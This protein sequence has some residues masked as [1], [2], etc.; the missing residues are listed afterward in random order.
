MKIAC[1]NEWL[2]R[3]A[4]GMTLVLTLVPCSLSGAFVYEAS[5]EFLSS[6]DFNADGIADV[7][8]LDKNTGNARVGYQNN[9]GALTWSAPLVTGIE[10]P[11]GC[12]LGRL[13]QSDRDALAVTSPEHNR[14]HLVNLSNTNAAGAPV[15]VTPA[16]IGPNLLI[17]LAT[18]FGTNATFDRLLIASSFNDVHAQG[19]TM[20]ELFA[21]AGTVASQFQGRIV[22][23]VASGNSLRLGAHPATF[24]AA[25]A[26]GSNAQFV[27]YAFTNQLRLV[28]QLSNLPPDTEYVFGNFNGEALPRFLFYVPGESNLL[29][30][31][32]VVAGAAFEFGSSVPVAL[33]QA[34]ERVYYVAQ[35]NDGYAI[36]HFRDGIQGLRVSGGTPVLASLYQSGLGAAGNVFTGVV[37]LGNGRFALLD[38]PAGAISTT[39]AQVVEF[40]GSSYTQRTNSNLSPLSTRTTRANLWLFQQEPF[41]TSGATFIGSLNAPDW[42]SVPSG[43]PASLSARV[44]TDGGSSSG[45]GSPSVNSLGTPPPG[46]AFGLPNQYRDDISFFSYAP[47][48]LEPLA[49]TISPPPG[50]YNG[51]IN[52]SFAASASADIFYR[53]GPA[54]GWHFYIVPFQLTNDATMQYYGVNRSTAAR[55]RLQSATYVLGRDN[56]PAQPPVTDPGN[57]NVPP[58]VDT[59]RLAYSSY[60]TVFY[61]RRSFFFDPNGSI[62][63]INLDGSGDRYVTAGARPR[64]SS[65]GRYLAFARETDPFNNRGNLWIRDLVTGQEAR[66]FSNS[67]SMVCYDWQYGRTNL[68][69]DFSCNLWQIGLNGVPIQLPL[70]HDCADDAPSY[71][72]VDGRLAFHNLS[73]T[74]GIRGLYVTSP[75]YSTAQ[76]LNIPIESPRWP[77]WSPDGRDIVFADGE[78]TPAVGAGKNIWIVKPDGTGLHPI[79]AL[80]GFNGFSHGAIWSPAGDALVGV[81]TVFN[82]YGIWVIPL[83]EDRTTCAGLPYRLPTTPGDGIDFVGGIHLPPPPPEL[84]IRRESGGVT[85]Y[86]RRTVI[87]YILE[88]AADPGVGWSTLS[89]PFPAVGLFSEHFIPNHLLANAQFFR[90]RTP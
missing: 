30:A 75:N 67:V 81:G 16:G 70:N 77:I 84:L 43:L 56:S 27:A 38:A 86:W 6:G 55:A 8:V 68:F 72:P 54:D 28:L 52:I 47:G 2:R 10:N 11:T 19:R 49:I 78:F 69:F 63:A 7:L 4:A 34:I 21:T 20:L 61:G 15:V 22:P 76:R 58:V 51:P 82:S 41:V 36:I 50:T 25:M 80:S 5:T 14:V 17:G 35:G 66:L 31:P 23:S 1:F 60:G 79:T 32:V 26:R 13:L 74:A 48:R 18:P 45:L 24:A 3:V 85:V 65:D 83:S 37:P 40:N 87:P 73:S 33:N 39:H 90:L 12:T 89:G 42:S 88:S 59:N 9:A 53:A 71:N 44:E 46:S 57:T 64:V 62:W 29:V